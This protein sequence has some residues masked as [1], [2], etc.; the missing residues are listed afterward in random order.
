[1]R[2][3]RNLPASR[4]TSLFPSTGQKN[5]LQWEITGRQRHGKTRQVFGKEPT[6]NNGI[7]KGDDR[8]IGKN[9]IKIWLK[10]E[11]GKIEIL[12]FRQ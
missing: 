2:Y 12:F 4:N 1:L 11:K 5:E 6:G 9:V 7:K 8:K 10:R 3:S